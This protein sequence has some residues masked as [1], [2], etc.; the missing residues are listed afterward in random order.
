MSTDRY[1]KLFLHL[2]HEIISMFLSRGALKMN[3]CN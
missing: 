3:M 1:L 2:F